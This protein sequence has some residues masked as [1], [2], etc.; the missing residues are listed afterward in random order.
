[1]KYKMLKEKISY[2]S[3]NNKI[4]LREDNQ[5][6]SKDL[7]ENKNI[8]HNLNNSQS[9]LI[10]GDVID[11][12]RKIP[13]ESISCI[14]TSPPYWKLRDYYIE[15]QIGQESTSEE[16]VDKIVEVSKELLR[17]LKKD[18]AY[19]LNLGDTYLEQ[20]LQMIPQRVAQKMIQDVKVL[21]KNQKKIG[22]LLRNQIIWHKPNHMPSPV[23]CRFTNTYEPIYFFTRNDWEKNVYFNLDAIR[24]PYKS[25]E[26]EN[27][28]GLPEY[29]DE[30]EYKEMLSEIEKINNKL[31][32]NG[33][34]KG[35]EVNIGASPGGRSSV[36][37]VKY[38]KKRKTEIEQKI[39]SEYLTKARIKKGISVKDINKILGYTY[40]AGHW[41]RSDAGGSLPTSIDWMKL[42]KILAFDNRYD[43]VMTETHYILQTIKKHPK[44]RNPGDIWTMSTAKL[45]EKH[46]AVFPE[47]LPRMAISA[48]CRQDGIVL[49]PFAGSGTTGKVA[50]EL[51][52]K[53]ILI[54]LQTQ[55]VDIIRR[56]CGDVKVISLEK[57]D[58]YDDFEENR[59][60]GIQLSQQNRI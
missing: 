26:K 42:K 57:D 52:R 28:F 9:L 8:I 14:V 48:C 46:F 47:E 32:Y 56:R 58:E 24:V 1:M 49:D 45:S 7:F 34:F 17:V 16:Y 44:G 38:I 40:T 35:E 55:F 21:G 5:I 18:G 39:I 33:K 53:S 30:K 54:E 43:K 27:T 11:V 31:K 2:K 29:L 25:T 13:S 23:K 6:Y 20:G 36:T 41:F 10:I 3:R 59:A 50:N 51:G 22:W 60:I 15:N 4:M 19:F 37:G 12:L